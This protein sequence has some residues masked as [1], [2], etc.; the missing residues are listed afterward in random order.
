MWF[1]VLMGDEALMVKDEEESPAMAK[2]REEARVVLWGGE[3]PKFFSPFAG[4]GLIAPP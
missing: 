3:V 2:D 4:Q 1:N